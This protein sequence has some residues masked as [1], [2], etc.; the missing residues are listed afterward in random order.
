LLAALLPVLAAACTRARAQDLDAEEVAPAERQVLL[1]PLIVA[2]PRL[3]AESFMFGQLGGAAQAHERFTSA[4][5]QKLEEAERDYGLSAEQKK[6]LLL[7][8]QGDIKHFFDEVQEARRTYERASSG[9]DPAA[10]AEN[11]RQIRRLR[12]KLMQDHFA[13]GS[14]FAKTL[15]K[16]VTKEQ[17][18]NR[19]KARRL[20]ETEHYKESVAASLGKLVRVLDLSAEQHE[21]LQEVV[22]SETPVPR[23]SGHSSHAYVMFQMSQLPEEKLRAFLLDSQ[24]ELLEKLLRAWKDARPF[25]ENDGFVFADEPP[26]VSRERAKPVRPRAGVTGR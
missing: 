7:A 25:L 1:N 2:A 21:R 6:K 9:N 12:L 23:K 4:L 15:G 22:L 13:A 11:A 5:L 3:D 24:W 16:T 10:V 17:L 26:G 19:D 8:G 14:L 18:A 20:F